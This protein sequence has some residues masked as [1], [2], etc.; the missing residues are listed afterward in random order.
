MDP[1]KGKQGHTKGLKKLQ[2]KQIIHFGAKNAKRLFSLVILEH[3]DCEN[4][5]FVGQAAKIW[6]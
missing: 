6:R 5:H 2:K 3:P 4:M 1:E